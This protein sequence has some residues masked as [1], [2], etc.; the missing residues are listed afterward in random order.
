MTVPTF[1]SLP[2]GGEV[3]PDPGRGGWTEA[4][5]EFGEMDAEFWRKIGAAWHPPRNVPGVS[6]RGSAPRSPPVLPLVVNFGHGVGNA[7][8]IQGEE[9]A[10]FGRSASSVVAGEG[11][12]GV[13]VLVL[14]K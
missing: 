12:G 3:D 7:W 2:G 9:V 5:Q 11:G 8:R 6:G 4:E 14:Y 10:V 1:V 13:N